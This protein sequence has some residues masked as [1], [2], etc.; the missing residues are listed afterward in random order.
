MK[1]NLF[2]CPKCAHQWWDQC[3]Y[4]TCDRCY[5]FFYLSATHHAAVECDAR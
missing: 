4:G 2:V 1:L 3:A 5:T